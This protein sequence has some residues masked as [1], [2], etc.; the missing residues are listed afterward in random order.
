MSNS[1]GKRFVNALL[2]VVFGL[3]SGWSLLGLAWSLPP[4]TTLLAQTFHPTP[5]LVTS[6]QASPNL[7]MYLPIVSRSLPT[8]EEQLLDLI[9][10]E[11]RARGLTSL[12]T[13]NLLMQVT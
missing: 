7:T 1:T 10:A 6:L 13:P 2:K 11:R 5:W 9:N 8:F 12:S 4:A 3:L